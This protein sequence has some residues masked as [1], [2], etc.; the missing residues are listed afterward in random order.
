MKFKIALKLFFAAL[1]LVAIAFIVNITIVKL[2]LCG[3]AALLL[4]PA[5]FLAIG[6]EGFLWIVGVFGGFAVLL[7]A[8]WFL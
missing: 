1:L 7:L 8:L 6:R 2:L 5:L 4:L 3:V